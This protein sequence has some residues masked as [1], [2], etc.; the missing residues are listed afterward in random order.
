MSGPP[1][2]LHLQAWAERFRRP[3]AL[4]DRA[5]ALADA[6]TPGSADEAW[7]ELHATLGLRAAGRRDEADAALARAA[8]GFARHGI[9]AGSRLCDALRALPLVAAG[10]GG[11]AVRQIGEI[12]PAEFDAA[13][14]GLP[15]VLM[16]Y[17][18][19]F[20]YWAR[21]MA[22]G[23]DGR[24]D[25]ALR[26]RYASVQQA[27]ATGDDAAIAHALA[28]LAAVQAD[29]CNAQGSL[30]LA[31]EAQSHGER[32]GRSLGWAM[33]VYNRL[34][35]LLALERDADAAQLARELLPGL[36]ELNPRNRESA[37]LLLGR[38]LLHGGDAAAARALLL[39]SRRERIVGHLAQAAL[40]EAELLLQGGDAA[41]ALNV[42]EAVLAGDRPGPQASGPDLLMLL[43]RH[44]SA[45]SERLGRI[46]AALHHARAERD[47]L[48]EV[49]SRG[50]Q[51]RRLALE[52]EHRLDQERLQREQAQQ[53]QR[54]AEAERERLDGLNRALAE[55]SQ[56]KT[57]FLAAASHDLRQPVQALAMNMAALQG[58]P[59]SPAQARLV[60]RMAQSLDALG[61]MFDGLL[62]IS[63]LDAGIVPAHPEP[64]ALRPL[65]QRLVDEHQARAAAAGLVLRL[66]LPRHAVAPMTRSD[67]SLLERCLR[68]LL[69]NALKYTPHGGVL[70]ALRA[71]GPAGEGAGDRRWRIDVID[72]GIG[73]A[74]EVQSRVFEEFY[75]ADNPERDR[76][77]GLGLG[78]SIVLRIGQLLGHPLQLRSRPG[79]GTRVSI[80]LPA[81]DEPASTGPAARPVESAGSVAA[82][83][84]A[85]GLC[86][87]VVDDDA[88]VRDS[89]VAVLERWGH[90]ALAGA[91]PT[92]V[93]RRWQRAGCPPA[94]ALVC[95]LRLRGAHDGVAAVGELRQTFGATLPALVVTGDTAPD[96]LQRL[97]ASGLPWL[98]KPVMP[99]RLRSWLA[100]IAAASA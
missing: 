9:A 8:K 62:D 45:A 14:T 43:H 38:A 32:A 57:R 73:M 16:A 93:M 94:Q 100:G 15:P 44:A 35:A 46:D 86:V 3:E 97:R 40:L 28:D 22:L 41:A 1:V 72:T 98:S 68:N 89:L 18:A 56:A 34:A 51:A 83:S 95:D 20:V 31:T 55:A 25:D 81:L 24:W 11:Q 91:D 19:Q 48:A 6:A 82:A 17:A 7:A 75:Q 78:G 27:R 71:L 39:R 99:M 30:A 37:C 69:D 36:D 65:L 21:A 88:D 67:A 77:R 87:L 80:E 4:L 90:V 2:A 63:R 52:I 26:D 50:A 13:G 84:P 85:G 70:L 61:R 92:E 66:R 58:E 49:L 64:L 60:G 12:D 96:R 53:R 59:L 33:A 54:D 79:R 47:R 23:A 10:Q 76:A 5:K 29:L 74:P 42:I